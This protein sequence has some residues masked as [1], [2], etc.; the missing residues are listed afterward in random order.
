MRNHDRSGWK[1]FARRPGIDNSL[2]PVVVGSH[3]DT[4]IAGGRFD[5]ILSVLT[6]LEIVRTL[7]DHNLSTRRPIEV[8]SWTNE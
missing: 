2:P 6:G 1:Y 5:G 8:V 3:L 4:Q 7:N